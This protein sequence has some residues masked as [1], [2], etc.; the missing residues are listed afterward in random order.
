MCIVIETK[1]AINVA[2]VLSKI[3]KKYGNVDSVADFGYN[4]V[5]NVV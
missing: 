1:T 4:L 3:S 2:D 5:I